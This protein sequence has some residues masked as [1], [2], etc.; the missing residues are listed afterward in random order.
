MVKTKLLLQ[1]LFYIKL[2]VLSNILIMENL[3]L[4]GLKS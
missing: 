3:V 4:V 1:A 2:K